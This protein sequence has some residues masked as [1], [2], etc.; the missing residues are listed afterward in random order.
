MTATVDRWLADL[1]QQFQGKRKIEVLIKAFA[2]QLAEVETVLSDINE[3]TD[4]FTASGVHLDL[5]GD[6]AC[7]SRKDA[8]GILRRKQNMEVSDDL[9]RLTLRYQIL[10]NNSEC[11]YYDIMES[12]ALLWDNDRIRYCERPERPATIF[13]VLPTAEI[14]ET[15]WVIGRVLAIKPAGVAVIFSA[16][17]R[18]PVLI[19]ALEQADLPFIKMRMVFRF[20]HFLYLDGTWL[21][22]GSSRLLGAVV[23]MGFRVIF[24]IKSHD[25]ERADTTLETRI[26]YRLLDGSWFLKEEYLLNSGIRKEEI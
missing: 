25:Q 26:N 18:F 22:D 12:L 24:K 8:L 7:L 9:Y 10:K 14:D 21:L 11:T 23:P 16:S 19:G 13:I 1:P 5:V 6:I 20:F 17:Y 4:L 2:K 15:D 3:K